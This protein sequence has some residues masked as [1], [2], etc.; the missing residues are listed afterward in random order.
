MANLQVDFGGM[1]MRN[2]IG[3]A[4]LNPSIAYARTPSVQ[5]DWLMRHVEAGA[6]YTP[7]TVQ[8]CRN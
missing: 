7:A 3:V 4:A 8:S 5:A 6:G 2:P 1:K